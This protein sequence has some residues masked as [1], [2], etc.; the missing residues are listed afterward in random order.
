MNMIFRA[1][2]LEQIVYGGRTCPELPE[3]P[4]AAQKKEYTE[5]QKDDARA[6]SLIATALGGPIAELVLTCTHAKE[7][8]DKLSAS[9]R[10]PQEDISTHIAKLQK[11]FVDLNEELK[12][13]NE[14]TLS[15]KMLIGRVL[16]TLDDEF[17]NFKDVWDT[18]PI[19]DQ[20]LNLLIEKLCAIEMRTE[21]PPSPVTALAAKKVHPHKCS[22]KS[23]KPEPRASE[24]DPK[25]KFP[26]NYCKKKGHWIADCPKRQNSQK[27]P[28]ASKPKS[29]A[30]ICGFI[31]Q[32]LNTSEE[33]GT[34]SRDWYCDSGASCHITWSRELLTDYREFSNP[35]IILVGKAGTTMQALGIGTVRLSVYA[36]GKWQSQCMK[37]VRYVPE[38]SANLF[39]VMAASRNG[40]ETVL[41]N[42]GLVI[43]TIKDK[44]TA[45]TGRLKNNLFVM[46]FKDFQVVEPKQAACAKLAS[47]PDLQSYHE[48]LGHQNNNHVKK[49]LKRLNLPVD[50]KKDSICDG[51]ALGKMHRLPFRPRPNKVTKVGEVIHADLCGP[52]ET[53]SIGKAKYFACF[54]DE[55]SKFRRLFFLKH[56]GET[57][58]ALKSFLNEAKTKGHI[59]KSLRCD[60]GKEFDNKDTRRMLSEFGIE[61][62][63]GPPHTPQQNGSAERENRTIVESARSMLNSSGL[64]KMLW[65]EAC[66]TAA[67]LL[68]LTGKSSDPNKT[69]HELWYGKPLTSIKHL[70]VFGTPCY[71]HV[72]KQNRQK[73]DDKALPG[74]FVGYVNDRDGYRVWIPTVRNVIRSHDVRFKEDRLDS[75]QNDPKEKLDI[76]EKSIVLEVPKISE[77]TECPNP[78]SPETLADSDSD[79]ETEEIERERRLRGRPKILR[80]GKPGRPRKIFQREIQ[81]S[82]N[83]NFCFLGEIPMKRALSG[84]ECNEWMRTMSEE[85]QSILRNDTWELVDRPED[86]QIIG[87]RMVLRNKFK[88]DGSF[89]RRKARLVAQGFNQKPGI[90]FK[91]TFAPVA[92][93]G[94]IRMAI[95]LAARYGMIIE[96]LDIASAYLQ[97]KLDET[98]FMEPPEQLEG[99][100]ELI[101]EDPKTNS[102]IR[103]K[104]KKMLKTARSGNKVCLLKKSLY[105]LRQAGR[106]WHRVLNSVLTSF[107]ARPTKSDPCL[108]SIQKENRSGLII[109]YVDD[110]L[111]I[112]RDKDMISFIK[113]KLSD[114]F[115]VR[116]L[117]IVKNCLG[118]EFSID[119]DKI[120]LQQRGYI[121]E[122]LTRFGMEECKPVSTPMD[123]GTKLQK[124]SKTENEEAE[125]LPYRE[126]V[127]ALTYLSV[128]TRPDIAFS[129]SYL[130]QFN[131]NYDNSHWIAAKRVLRYLKGTM[132]L[133]LVYERRAG[134]ITGYV[135]ADWGNCP[136]DRKSYTGY[137]FL[138]SG[139]PISWDSRKQKTVALSS[140]EAEFMALSDVLKEAKYLQKLLNELPIEEDFPSI[141]LHCDNLGAIK[142]AQNPVF[143][144]RTKHVDIRCHFIREALENGTV[145]LQHISTEEMIADV[146]TKGLTR[147]KHENCVGRLIHPVSIEGK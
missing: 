83:A 41:N 74:N 147:Q 28:S 95:A 143:H 50:D 116:E 34:N 122:L 16:S 12:K 46:N 43:R 11:L 93:L 62:L 9:T 125:K 23:T 14:N 75:T 61:I 99:I 4:T 57:H 96:Q 119:E 70:R 1:H 29:K 42:R 54:K 18:I 39:S 52:M 37:N 82:E 78:E 144:A 13:Q 117:G 142:L 91:E 111:V 88:A 45:A 131:D 79:S 8:W 105:G 63:I 47:A 124:P 121:R 38:A 30:N 120:I 19:K 86:K 100:L 5:W 49:L 87:S 64:P 133:G 44:I 32:A 6:A 71:V 112:S 21:A 126:L 139:G 33:K 128:A 110:I 114:R 67:Y 135:D 55:F 7:I 60:G 76:P 89:E 140:T 138:F 51:C 40:F 104:A 53:E 31:T 24:E 134:G 2:G 73:F 66:N 36:S 84:N 118:I 109:V 137:V 141:S 59:V 35:E 130:G 20:T 56:K 108:Y 65:A 3:A 26:C 72:P 127:G 48:R 68:N 58:D 69:P 129:V 146:L 90:H 80:T 22:K 17:N 145:S 106:N 136:M 85:I 103:K 123:L 132:D 81:D 25:S 107:G 98:I 27:N 77:T 92:R 15:E 102:D 101:I 113:S 10:N 94:T 115:D 97:G